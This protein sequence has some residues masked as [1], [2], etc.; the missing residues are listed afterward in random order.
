MAARAAC[1]QP[2]G[3]EAAPPSS[4]SA[5]PTHHVTRARS[6]SRLMGS[7]SWIVTR[8][9]RSLCWLFSALTSDA[10]SSTKRPLLRAL[11]LY[12]SLT[13]PVIT[14]WMPAAAQ[15]RKEE[16]VRRAAQWWRRR[17]S[18]KRRREEEAERKEGSRGRRH[19]PCLRAVAACSRELPVPKLKPAT[20]MLPGDGSKHRGER[21]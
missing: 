2:R 16:V 17:A 15:G 5:P 14:T 10:H 9:F 21:H 6:R 3:Q 7:D 1:R 8:S 12:V 20:R 18:R 13:L 19:A 11:R 4:A